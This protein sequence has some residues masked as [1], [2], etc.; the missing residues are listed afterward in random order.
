MQTKYETADMEPTARA[1]ES[2]LIPCLRKFG[3]SLIVYNPLAAG[4]FS[5]KYTTLDTPAE[6]RFSLSSSMGKMYQARFFKQSNL[7]ALAI[8]EPVATKHNIPLI[9]V[10]LRWVFHHSQLKP[11]SK[12]GDDAMLLGFSSYEQLVQ[13]VEAAEKG[14]LPDDLVEALDKAWERARGDAPTYWR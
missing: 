4:L 9:E 13:N 6:G 14:P 5:G 2:E 12:G 7:D 8:V 10:G 1:A 11:A 3:I